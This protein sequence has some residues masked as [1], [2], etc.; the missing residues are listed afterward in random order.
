M[1]RKALGAFVKAVRAD[2]GSVQRYRQ[3]YHDEAIPLGRLP[4]DAVKKIGFQMMVATRAMQ[5][6]RDLKVPLGAQVSSRL[7]RHLYGAEIHWD[8]TLDGGVTIVHGNG[9]VLS[10]R[11]TV[12]EGCILFHNVTL[13]EGL[14]PVSRESGAP[15]LGKDVHVGPG[16]TLLG[17]IHV[18]D[19]T[20]IMAGAVLTRSVPPNSLVKPAE[21]TVST[22]VKPAAAVNEPTGS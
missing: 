20:K 10:H 15:T 3:K 5:L 12:G 21:A 4:V 6:V 22:R 18:G 8:T 16:A 17:P 1:I 14:D 7:I 9:L 2:Y 11:A 19:G 13:G